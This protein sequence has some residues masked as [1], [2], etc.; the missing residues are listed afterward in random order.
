LQNSVLV[1]HRE[2]DRTLLIEIQVVEDFPQRSPQR[3]VIDFAAV[4]GAN[5]DGD[6][7]VDKPLAMA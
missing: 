7:L 4:V 5:E 6:I 3:I 2:P 1:Q